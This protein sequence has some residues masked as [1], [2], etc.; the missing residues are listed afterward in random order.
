MKAT[1][2]WKAQADELL[3]K[4]KDPAKGNEPATPTTNQNQTTGESTSTP[5]NETPLSFENEEDN[6]DFMGNNDVLDDSILDIEMEDE[7]SG[8]G[9]NEK[10]TA[11]DVSIAWIVYLGSKNTK[12]NYPMRGMIAPRFLEQIAEEANYFFQIAEVDTHIQAKVYYG[13][14]NF[15]SAFW[16]EGDAIV[17]LGDDGKILADY[18]AYH[19]SAPNFALNNFYKEDIDGDN[20]IKST[21]NPEKSSLNTD[22]EGNIVVINYASVVSNVSNFYTQNP[23]TATGWTIAHGIGHNATIGGHD[24]TGMMTEGSEVFN[25]M[26]T[27]YKTFLQDPPPVEYPQYPKL[28]SYIQKATYQRKNNL[29]KFQT[30]RVRGLYLLAIPPLN[31]ISASEKYMEPYKIKFRPI[32]ESINY[33][34]SVKNHFGKNK[35]FMQL[36]EDFSDKSEYEK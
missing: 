28:K 19:L 25:M 2:Y 14:Y 5:Q 22:N 12:S 27:I 34:R 4:K 30:E 20:F 11:F 3:G 15:K 18:V 23:L 33:V 26:D 16:R 6:N 7:I 1:D 31:Q 8:G 32:N 21:R 36:V 9:E 29:G 10:T 17:V 35:G 13:N 24:N